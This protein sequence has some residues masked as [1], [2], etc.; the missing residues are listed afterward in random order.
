MSTLSKF[1]HHYNQLRFDDMEFSA[2][3]S[4]LIWNSVEKFDSLSSV[5]QAKRD[6]LYVEL[7]SLQAIRGGFEA[8]AIRVGQMFSFQQQMVGLS[9]D[10]QESLVVAKLFLSQI[11]DV[12]DEEEQRFDADTGKERGGE[13]ACSMKNELG[14]VSRRST[15]GSASQNEE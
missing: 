15:D 7:H 3:L 14:A 2:L 5:M 1:F 10:L 8:G 13:E 9:A 6:Q 12:W 4:I 11:K